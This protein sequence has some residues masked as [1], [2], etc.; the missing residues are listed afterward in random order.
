[1]ESNQEAREKLTHEDEEFRRLLEKHHEHDRRLEELRARRYLTE[2]EKVEEVRLKKVK[3]SL[4]DR[5]ESVVRE[6]SGGGG[7]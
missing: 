7:S 1:M 5:M 3:L 2:E 6:R 4:K